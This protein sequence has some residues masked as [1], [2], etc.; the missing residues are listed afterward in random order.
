MAVDPLN[1]IRQFV[2]IGKNAAMLLEAAVAEARRLGYSWREI[3]EALG[4][5]F[6]AAH[7]RF[8]HIELVPA[9][10]VGDA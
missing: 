10:Q 4:T 7:Q 3:G 6:Q 8:H 2:S 5:S 1:E 9:D